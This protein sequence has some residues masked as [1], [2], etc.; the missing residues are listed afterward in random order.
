MTPA[1]FWSQPLLENRL[2][3][4]SILTNVVIRLFTTIYRL[5]EFSGRR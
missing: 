5:G 3:L 4:Q 1:G 2:D